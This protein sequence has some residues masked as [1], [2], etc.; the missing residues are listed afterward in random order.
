LNVLYEV[1]LARIREQIE[2]VEK[3]N[4]DSIL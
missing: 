3:R 4:E 2:E 1:V